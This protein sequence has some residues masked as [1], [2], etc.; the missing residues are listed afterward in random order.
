MMKLAK[1]LSEK[2][3]RLVDMFRVL[4]KQNNLAMDKVEFIRRMKIFEPR[5][6]QIDVKNI[7]NNLANKE[8]IYY[9]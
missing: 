9:R 1:Y 5:L 8:T 2:R 3:M 4:D 6:T 7:A